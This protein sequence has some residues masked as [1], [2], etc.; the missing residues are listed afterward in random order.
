M[1]YIVEYMFHWFDTMH[2]FLRPVVSVSS[3][4]FWLCLSP[5]WNEWEILHLADRK[6]VIGNMVL[7]CSWNLV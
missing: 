4:C 2:M 6:V 3:V 7:F 1:E 5:L